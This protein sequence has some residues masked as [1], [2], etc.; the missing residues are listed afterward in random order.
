MDTDGANQNLPPPPD[1]PPNGPA[2]QTLTGPPPSATPQDVAPASA[3]PASSSKD[4]GG[5][6]PQT[7][8]QKPKRSV[9]EET[10]DAKKKRLD[11]AA[12]EALRAKS[13]IGAKK[14]RDQKLINSG[15][16]NAKV[17]DEEDLG[18]DA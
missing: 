17:G 12:S 18:L 8:P 7:T 16:E 3:A 14:I 4:G 10:P 13:H 11:T 15:A 9:P 6:P 5:P 2:L 1:L